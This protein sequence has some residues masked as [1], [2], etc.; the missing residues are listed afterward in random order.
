[1]K[2]KIMVLAAAAVLLVVAGCSKAKTCRCAVIG[3]SKVRIIKIES[4][5]CEDIHIYRYHT[6]LDS[7]KIDSLVC[8]DYEFAI[9]S[10]YND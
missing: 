10:I 2:R 3:T 4:G 1:M 6:L 5:N 7:L 9:D 8:T